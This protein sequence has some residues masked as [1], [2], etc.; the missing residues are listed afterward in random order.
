MNKLFFLFVVLLFSKTHSQELNCTV[1]INAQSLTNANQ[2]IFATLEKSLNEFVNNTKWTGKSYLQKEKIDCTMFINVSSYGSDQFVAT[3]QV[4][5]SRPIYGSTYSSPVLN[6]NDKDFN[7]KYIEYENLIY[8]PN[9]FDSNLI[10]VMAFYAH[11]IIG[12]DA[13]TFA[14]MSG[15][16]HY[17]TAQE[18]ASV[19]QQ[20]NYKG[21]N[22]ADGN[23]SRHF[24]VNDMLSGTFEP[25]RL[26]LYDYHFK[27]LDRMSEDLKEGKENIKMALVSL[28][29]MHATRPNAFL[30][31]VFFDAKSDEILSIF[32]G[33]PQIGITDLTNSLNKISPLNAS[34]WAAI[35]F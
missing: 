12:M 18:I 19:A 23:Q 1:R 5:S 21:W 14:P 31:R 11:M 8:N 7:F 4:S 13:D 9:S 35:K 20:G 6:Y 30:T 17:R 15:T 28:E 2:P 25:I 26:A 3:I 22:Q 24:L 33:G 10:S 27:G 29:K 32:S 16:P 34:K